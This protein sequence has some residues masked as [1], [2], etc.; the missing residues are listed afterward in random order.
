MKPQKTYEN[1]I[2]RGFH[3]DPS[4]LRAGDDYYVVNSTFQYFPAILISHSR[5]LVH[6][7]TIGHAITE[8]SS[9]DLSD[10]RDSHGIWAPDISFHN[11]MYYILATLRLNDPP[12][13]KTAPRR[14][15]LMMKSETPAGPYSTPVR[16]DVDSIDPSFFADDDGNCYLV[17]S[18]GVCVAKLD[19]ENMKLLERPTQVWAGTGRKSPEGPHIFKRNGYYY[20]VLAEG[21][22]EYG[23]CVTAARSKN[24]RGPYEPCP[25]NP[26]FTQNDPH[27]KLQRCGH[28][29]FVTTQDGSW[30]MVYL[31]GRPNGGNYTT[32]GRETALDPVEW[33]ED[34]WFT[35][36]HGRGPSEGQAAPNLPETIYAKNTFDDFDSA[37][38]SP[39][40]EF[41]RNPDEKLYSLTQKP[42][43]FR[44]MTG[45]ASLNGVHP[46]NTLLRREESFR[47]TAA[48]RM[49]FHPARGERAGLVC[50]Y[51]H[52]NHIELFLTGTEGK[53]EVMLE[54]NRNGCKTCLGRTKYS[55]TDIFLR[56][57]VWGQKRS[58][59]LSAG[60]KNW[61]AVGS[62]PDCTFLSDED[63][64]EGKH[65]TGTLVGIF[66][67]NGGSGSHIPADFDWFRYENESSEEK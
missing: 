25:Y 3:P 35:V 65:H 20:S 7:E 34:G 57:R 13:G 19:A 18:P 32:L 47:F 8:S 53:N 39:E 48:L 31:C 28:G 33:N 55:G 26:V 29:D 1:P 50:Y 22:T 27:A 14:V 37:H 30:W 9:L 56:V 52:R 36:N 49:K 59:D 23:H 16:L 24:L 44:I 54:E 42:G 2:L 64:T 17:I 41:V 60:G 40:W 66:A 15:Q 11:G 67:V 5:D 10:L 62:E 38:L 63:V 43:C 45:A 51:G 61:T 58:F 21:G 46:V 12:E 4:I 6:W